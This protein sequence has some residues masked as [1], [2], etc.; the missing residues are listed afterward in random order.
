MLLGTAAN[1]AQPDKTLVCHVPEGTPDNIQIIE[2]GSKG[3]AL[4]AHILHGD[5]EVT[6][7]MCDQFPDN[8]CDG[9]PDDSADNDADCDDGDDGTIDSC[10]TGECVFEEIEVACP[11][12]DIYTTAIT[13]YTFASSSSSSPGDGLIDGWDKCATEGFIDGTITTT[14]QDSSSQAVAQI[15]LTAAIPPPAL[16]NQLKGCGAVTALSTIFPITFWIYQEEIDYGEAAE[17][18]HAAC[19]ALQESICTP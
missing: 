19:V 18:E 11:C 12:A 2:V 6:A 10:D 7:P 1:A 13:H 15:A 8:D 5:W 14:D 3:G 16:P 4:V 9:M 17:E